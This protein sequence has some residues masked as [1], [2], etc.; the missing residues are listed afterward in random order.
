MYEYVVN[1]SYLL[2]SQ[3]ETNGTLQG[4]IKM[5]LQ[6]C[7]VKWCEQVKGTTKGWDSPRNSNSCHLLPTLSLEGQGQP[8]VSL[9]YRRTTQ[10]KL[11]PEGGSRTQKMV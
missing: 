8:A 6:W 4:F 3:H 2:E 1:G 5:I 9:S 7:H 11:Q 10:S